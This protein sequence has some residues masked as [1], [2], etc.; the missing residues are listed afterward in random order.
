MSRTNLY[1]LQ[2]VYICSYL[3][4]FVTWFKYVLPTL[5]DCLQHSCYLYKILIVY[6]LILP[7]NLI[8]YIVVIIRQHKNVDV[9]RIT[10]TFTIPNY[11][12]YFN[13]DTFKINCFKTIISFHSHLLQQFYIAPLSTL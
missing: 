4:S 3:R 9:Y 1:A 2:I 12:S 8:I 7:H 5:E 10:A 6:N 13:I 11:Y